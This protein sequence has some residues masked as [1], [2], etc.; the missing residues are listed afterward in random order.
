[1]KRVKSKV[2][3]YFLIGSTFAVWEDHEK[4]TPFRLENFGQDSSILALA[5]TNNLQKVKIVRV[6]HYHE[7]DLF[8]D[9]FRFGS[10]SL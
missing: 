7:I 2:L 4:I 8:S 6:I 1:M 9:A 3:R 10:L 5:G